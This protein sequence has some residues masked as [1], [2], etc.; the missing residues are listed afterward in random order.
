MFLALIVL[1]ALSRKKTILSVDITRKSRIKILFRLSMLEITLSLDLI[2][3]YLTFNSV[4][5]EKVSIT[6][7]CSKGLEWFIWSGISTLHKSQIE[8]NI[9]LGV[10]KILAIKYAFNLFMYLEKLS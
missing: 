2:S 9:I 3:S 6:N 8:L 4:P 10:S 1:L 7:I 5:S